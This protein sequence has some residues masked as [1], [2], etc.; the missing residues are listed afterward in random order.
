MSLI[1]NDISGNFV[2]FSILRN[3]F[4]KILTKKINF[5]PVYGTIRGI[6]NAIW[7]C[8][9]PSSEDPF[10]SCSSPRSEDLFWS[11]SSP[12]SEDPFWSCSSPSS[13][14]PRLGEFVYFHHTRSQIHYGTVRVS[15]GIPIIPVH[16]S[17][18]YTVHTGTPFIPYTVLTNVQLKILF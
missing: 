7:I 4:K 13:E 6:N 15:T 17:Y 3:F 14:D 1:Q 2:S 16:R 10:W 12:S 9:S 5:S 8:S 11:C 18:R